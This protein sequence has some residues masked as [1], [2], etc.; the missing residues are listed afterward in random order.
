[1]EPTI[2]KI[3]GQIV[4]FSN[5]AKLKVP[6]DLTPKL[7]DTD[8]TITLDSTRR[9]L[10]YPLDVTRKQFVIGVNVLII[11]GWRKSGGVDKPTLVK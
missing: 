9:V 10:T 7:N 1:M 8:I 2:T 11:H 4:Y 5:G 3:E 6:W